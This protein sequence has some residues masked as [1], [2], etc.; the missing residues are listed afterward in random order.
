[1]H[2]FLSPLLHFEDITWLR[3][4]GGCLDGQPE[5]L[6]RAQTGRRDGN[7][8]RGLVLGE[9]VVGGTCWP[10][11]NSYLPSATGPHNPHITLQ[12]GLKFCCELGMVTIQET[13]LSSWTV[14]SKALE[15]FL[16]L[17]WAW[18]ISKWG[19]ICSKW[20][21][22]VFSACCVGLPS[23]HPPSHSCC[24]AFAS[25]LFVF[26]NICVANQCRRAQPPLRATNWKIWFAND[27]DLR[28]VLLDWGKL[29]PTFQYN[30]SQFELIQLSADLKSLRNG[31]LTS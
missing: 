23:F 11:T 8:V 17:P 2:L 24:L 26:W 18:R 1:M 21:E 15:E 19:Q 20:T 25:S 10:K 31:L 29:G 27:I 22:D 28:N 30:N 13:Q 16:R 6:V 9:L 12:P 14:M 3:Y 7:H 4:L 5:A